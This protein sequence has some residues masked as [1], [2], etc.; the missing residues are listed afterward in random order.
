M[1]IQTTELDPTAQAYTDD[2]IV[3]KVNAATI[4]VDAVALEA[5]AARINLDAMADTERGYVKVVEDI[6]DF[7]ITGVKRKSNGKI[8]F[9]WDDQP[10]V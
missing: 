5:G 1:A 7:V 3:S 4:K 6:G 8:V 10:V 2:E 9:F